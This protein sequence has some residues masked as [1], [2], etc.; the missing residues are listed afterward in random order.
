[1]HPWSLLG[2]PL[3]ANLPSTIVLPF[4]ATFRYAT[5]QL[6]LALD[7]TD[8]VMLPV[9]HSCYHLP[10]IWAT[11]WSNLYMQPSMLPTFPCLPI[12]LCFVHLYATFVTLGYR[13]APLSM[14]PYRSRCNRSDIALTITLPSLHAPY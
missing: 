14:Q 6:L 9:L 1:M 13:W 5:F 10:T 4:Y 7:V 2:Q 11:T 3:Y 12:Y 8:T